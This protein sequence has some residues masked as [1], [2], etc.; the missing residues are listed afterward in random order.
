[1]E[2][3]IVA[4]VTCPKESVEKIAKELLSK[5]VAACVNIVQE[6]QSMYWWEDKIEGSTESLLLVKTKSSL[7]DSLEKIVKSIHPYDLPEIIAIPIVRGHN[8]YLQ[9]IDRETGG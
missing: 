9:W 6:V 5:K 8:P 2:K 3:Y 4:L 7:F 1:M